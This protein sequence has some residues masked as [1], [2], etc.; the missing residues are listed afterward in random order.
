MT[1]FVALLRGVNVGRAK[2]VPMATLRDLLDDLGYADVRT[3]LNSGNAVFRAT[4]GSGAAHADAIRAAIE[5]ALAF[6]VPVIVKSS[7]ELAA[8]VEENPFVPGPAD[9]SRLLVA[10]TPDR[11][12]LAGLR[13]I[14]TLVQPPESF[15]VGRNAAYLHCPGGILQ[16]KA[17]EAL[18]G[19]AGAGATTRNWATTL[20]LHEMARGGD[21][22]RP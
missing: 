10:F 13:P 15:H 6:T 19:R 8:I 5:R 9:P 16:S 12:S 2:R 17:G 21:P 1:T 7:T 22:R 14:E 4:R 20:K 11:G 3:L 18:L